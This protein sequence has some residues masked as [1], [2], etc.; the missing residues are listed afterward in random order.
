MEAFT[1]TVSEFSF[2]IYHEESP[3]LPRSVEMS[4]KRRSNLLW[5]VGKQPSVSVNC[6]GDKQN[7][8]PYT[9][10]HDLLLRIFLLLTVTTL[11][12]I[13]VFFSPRDTKLPVTQ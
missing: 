9:F 10:H 7:C 4:G 12:F 13:T 11:L 1:V 2:K 6:F 3:I 5:T 8:I